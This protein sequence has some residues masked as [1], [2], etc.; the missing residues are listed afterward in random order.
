LD[1][2][3]CRFGV[4]LRFHFLAPVE[5]NTMVNGPDAENQAN[6]IT[7]GA[8]GVTQRTEELIFRNDTLTNDQNRP[9]TSVHNITST[10]AQP[11]GVVLKDR[12]GPLD[13][14]GWTGEEALVGTV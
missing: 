8:E 5:G 7:I 9:T 2:S 3:Q 11:I 12:A 10:R 6:V 14:D 13:R 4:H 1:R